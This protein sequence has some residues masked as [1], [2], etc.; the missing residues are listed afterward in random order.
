MNYAA[1]R[2]AL[3]ILLSTAIITPASAEDSNDSLAIRDVIDRQIA[4]FKV[5]DSDLAYSFTS[6]GI[7]QIF[8]TPGIF[9]QMVEQ[10][11]E[12]V[13]RPRSYAFMDHQMRGDEAVQLVDVVGPHGAAW[14]AVYSL[15]RAD[16]GGWVITGCELKLGAG[17]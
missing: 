6:P 3:L 14:V 13:Y 1:I 2:F 5:G 17:A 7:Q 4:A 15:R 16:N 8:P 10:G 11:Y 9:M 12:P